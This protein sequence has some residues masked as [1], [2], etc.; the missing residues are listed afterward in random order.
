MANAPS[1][2]LSPPPLSTWSA[3]CSIHSPF[4]HSPT[5]LLA[6]NATP[7]NA[8]RIPP[9]KQEIT[10]AARKR[11]VWSEIQKEINEIL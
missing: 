7:T 10:A 9:R 4:S 11:H 6:V 8:A 2:V 5:D 3:T 1:F